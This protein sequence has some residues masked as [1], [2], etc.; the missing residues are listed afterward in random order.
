MRPILRVLHA[1]SVVAAP[2]TD[3]ISPVDAPPRIHRRRAILIRPGE[4][5]P[6]GLLYRTHP[7]GPCREL[8]ARKSVR[9]LSSHCLTLRYTPHHL[10]RFTSGSSSSHSSSDHSSSRRS[11]LS[12]SLSGH[13]PPETIVADLFTPPRFVYPPLARTP[14]CSEAYR[15]WRS[16]PLSTMYRP[17]T[18]ESSAGDSSSESSARPSCKRCRSPAATV[19]SPIHATRALVPS[20][21]DLLPPRKRFRDSIS[22]EDSV[23]EDIDADELADIKAD[24]TTVE[25]TVD[26]DLTP[27]KSGCSGM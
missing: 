3:I 12:H 24:A 9:P 16:A 1:P 13:T 14:R 8:T 5:I 4:D 15:H 26:R 17:T 19:T 18:S 6:I 27:P 10:D 25:V 22:I 20:R 7:G 11:I 23:E 2:S 21:V